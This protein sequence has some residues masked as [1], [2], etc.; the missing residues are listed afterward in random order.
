LDFYRKN[1]GKYDEEGLGRKDLK[2]DGLAGMNGPT[3]VRCCAIPGVYRTISAGWFSPLDFAVH[4]SGCVLVP[5]KYSAPVTAAILNSRMSRYYAFLLL[6]SAV[7]QR[8][9]CTFYPRTLEH[10]P[11][12][13]LA[14]WQVRK[15]HKLAIEASELSARAAM[16]VTD[17]YLEFMENIG[18]FT[19]AGFLGLRLAEGLEE[20][21]R[22]RLA[23]AD[24]PQLGLG[25]RLLAADDPDLEL[26]G[27]VA[28]LATDDDEFSAQDV[29]NLPLPAEASARKQLAE[30]VRNYAAD[31][32]RTQ[33]RAS[34]AMEEVDEVVAEG[35][36]LSAAEHEAI[37]KRC[38]EFP[39]SITAERPRF[40]WNPERKRQARRTYR[41]GERFKT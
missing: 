24:E 19:K 40:A 13:K 35:L 29:E 9:H 7:I 26:L 8:A 21:D 3:D 2:D 37:R 5:K 41:P 30:R 25:F 34:G 14:A 22:E 28:L 33:D 16:S 20:I 18:T 23:P 15:L 11:F 38:R 1:K 17:I 6:R 36:G 10:V 27:T 39:L 12:P 31:L 32:K 4:N